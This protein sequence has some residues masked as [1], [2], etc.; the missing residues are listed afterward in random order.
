MSLFRRC[1]KWILKL[2]SGILLTVVL[3][4]IV[5][6]FE[7]SY[8]ALSDP[9]SAGE[10]QCRGSSKMPGEV[11]LCK[12]AR[13]VAGL[14]NTWDITL[15]VESQEVKQT[16]DVVLV[17]DHSGSMSREARMEAAKKSAK[18]FVEKLLDGNNNGLTRVGLVSFGTV[19]TQ[20]LQLGTNREALDRVIDAITIRGGTFTQDGIR[21]AR[22]MLENST[23]D[24]K[25]I[26]L[27]S[28]GQ[29]TFGYTISHSLDYDKLITQQSIYDYFLETNTNLELEDF[30]KYRAGDGRTLRYYSYYYR[31]GFPI[32]LNHGNSAIA[33]ARFAKESSHM[34]SVALQAGQT[35]QDI[36]KAIATDRDSYTE[37]DPKGLEKVFTNIAGSIVSPINNAKVVDPM[38]EGFRVVGNPHPKQGTASYDEKSATLSWDVESLNQVE[39]RDGNRIKFEEMTYRVEIDDKLREVPGA[40]GQ[41]ANE[42]HLYPT[43]KEAQLTYVDYLGKQKAEAFPKPEVNP[44]LI[45][46]EKRV[47]DINGTAKNSA[48]IFDIELTNDRKDQPKAKCIEEQECSEVIVYKIAPKDSESAKKTRQTHLRYTGEYKVTEKFPGEI[49]PEDYEVSYEVTRSGASMQK[50]TFVV[51]DETDSDV[52]IVV[53][54]RE[55]PIELVAIKEWVGL[56]APHEVT[57]IP[58]RSIDGQTWEDVSSLSKKTADGT[59]TWEKLDRFDTNGKRYQY[60]VKELTEL[61]NVSSEVV[62]QPTDEQ[63]RGSVKC[64]VTNTAKPGSILWSKVDADDTDKYLE[65][66]VW[67]LTAENQEP[68]T[69]E[70]C[71]AESVESCSGLDKNPEAGKFEVLNLAWGKWSIQEQKAP[72]GYLID[73]EQ[74]TAEINGEKLEVD[75]G[76]I[77]NHRIEPPTLPL[78]GGIGRDHF[79]I[80]GSFLL[81]VAAGLI[82]RNR[83]HAN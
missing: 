35:G 74:R 55:K 44:V 29:P 4:V 14:V 37:A 25:H 41:V 52:N 62:C 69:V 39:I 8:A 27:L 80:A 40:D 83:R 82:W 47:L 68:K 61:P 10:D 50:N 5:G 77:E 33:E 56:T 57:L 15:R 17:I 3:L 24:H 79:Y 9:R 46:V 1:P 6:N 20:D 23:A 13:P 76:K 12:T 70:D 65:D 66:S 71:V 26:V 11:K 43:N 60:R 58:Q 32:V 7:W 73:E 2:N 34:W 19:A 28:D 22:L 63:S 16:S 49:A 36:L 18:T 31:D 51:K 38:G 54:N 21:K 45:S 64:T 42:K 72:F 81:L 75:L 59:A 30:G 48:Q 53:T 78:T 67:T